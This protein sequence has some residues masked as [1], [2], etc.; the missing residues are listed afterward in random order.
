MS[1]L[2]FNQF[3]STVRQYP[4]NIAIETDVNKFNYHELLDDVN[5]L[6]NV[7]EKIDP[8]TEQFVGLNID[9]SYEYI[10]ALL[11]VNKLKKIFAPMGAAYPVKRIER[12]LDKTNMRILITQQGYEEV[13]KQL[14]LENY[15]SFD[16]ECPSGIGFTIHQFSNSQRGKTK[17]SLE[18]VA[19]LLSTSGSTGEPKLILGI[20]KGLDHFI[21]WQKEKFFIGVGCRCSLLSPVT[22]DVSLR[23]ILVPLYSG[24]AIVIPDSSTRQD[25]Y[26]LLQ[27]L[28]KKQI[29]LTHMVPTIFRGLLTELESQQGTY[30]LSA[31]SHVVLPG[32]PLYA[33]DVVQWEKLVGRNTNLVI[34]YGPS[35]TS[36]AKLFYFV[37]FERHYPDGVI[38]IGELLPD[39]EISILDEA[40][41]EIAEGQVGELC[42]HTH[43][44][45]KGYL[46]LPQ[47][48]AEVF[49]DAGT[50]KA[51]Y[52]TGDLVFRGEDGLIYF[53]GRKDH[54]V[55]LRGQRIELLEV[56]SVLKQVANV[57]HAVAV[58]KTDKQ[59][60]EK[61]VVYLGGIDKQALPVDKIRQLMQGHLPDYMLP[62][63]IMYLDKLP[64]NAN[65]KVDRHQLPDLLTQ[66]P[67]LTQEYV[68]AAT[69]FEIKLVNIWQTV[70]GLEPLGIRDNFFDLGGTSNQILAMLSELRRTFAKEV[71]VGNAFEYGSIEKLAAF[72][73]SDSPSSEKLKARTRRIKNNTQTEK[74][75]AIVGMALSVPD[76][77]TVEQFWKNLLTGKESITFFDNNL[78]ESVSTNVSSQSNYVAARGIL[79]NAWCFDAPFFNFSEREAQVLDPQQRILL[80]LSYQA[81]QDA[82]IVNDNYGGLIGVFAGVGDNSYYSK[83]LLNNEEAQLLG[84]QALRLANEKDYVATRIAHVLNLK[85]MAISVHTACSTSLV[86]VC[87]AV[88]ALR[89]GSIDSALCGGAYIPYPQESGHLHAEG[90]FASKDGHC[91]PFDAEASGTLFSSGAGMV[92]LKRLS[93]AIEEGDHV[94][95]TIKGVGV[96]N[97]GGGKMSFMSPSVDGQAQAIQMAVD[98]AAVSHDSIEY[99]EAHGTATPLGDPIEVEALARIYK[100]VKNKTRLLG[101][102]KSNLGHLDAAAGVVGLIKV[103]LSLKYNTLPPSINY[104]TPNPAIPFDA[105]SFKVND[106][107]KMLDSEEPLQRV[108]VSSFGVGGTNAHVIV[109]APPISEFKHVEKNI[110]GSELLLLSAESAHSLGA[111]E[112]ALGNFVQGNKAIKISQVAANLA[113]NR[114]HYSHRSFAVCHNTETAQDI[115]QNRPLKAY[116]DNV[117]A[118]NKQKKVAFLFPGQGSQHVGM[119]ACFYQTDAVYTKYLDQ[120]A[121]LLA[122]YVDWDIRDIL[123]P[124]S[125]EAKQTAN[126]LINQTAYSQPALFVVCYAM[127]K[128]WQHLGVQ[129]AAM[130]GH[131]IGEYVAAC[132]AEVLN[133]DDALK[134]ILARGRLMQSM[135]E[136]DMLSVSLS[137]AEL[138]PYLHRQLSIAAINSSKLTVVAGDSNSI[139]ALQAELNQKSIDNKL[140]VT[141]HAF[142]S[143]MMEPVLNEFAAEFQQVKL[144]QA[145]TTIISS[146]TADVLT[147]AQATDINY[148]TSHVRNPVRFYQAVETLWANDDYI[149]LEVG[150]RAT[151][152]AL[153]NLVINDPAKQLAIASQGKSVELADMQH[154]F[155]FAAGQLWT[156]GINLDW[157]AWYQH[158]LVAKLSLPNYIFEPL[159]YRLDGITTQRSQEAVLQAQTIDDVGQQIARLI[160]QFTGTK[161]DIGFDQTFIALGLDSL[162]L[163]QFSL[164]LQKIFSVQI[165]VSRLLG[166][167]VTPTLLIETIWQDLPDTEELSEPEIHKHVFDDI[168]IVDVDDMSEQD[169]S[170]GMDEKGNPQWY[171]R[172]SDE[173]GYYYQYK[174]DDKQSSLKR[175]NYNPFRKGNIESVV[176]M[177][178]S[179]SEIWLSAQ[180]DDDAS[181]AFNLSLCMSFT[182]KL[183]VDLLEKAIHIIV[184][185]HE[186]LRSTF[187]AD[188]MAMVIYSDVNIEFNQ[189]LLAGKT[190]DERLEEL[191]YEEDNICN[192]LFDLANGPLFRVCLFKLNDEKSFLTFVAH[193]MVVDG[194]SLDLLI[195][196][197]E[198]VYNNLI[199]QRKLDMPDAYSIAKYNSAIVSK[200]LEQIYINAEKYWVNQYKDSIPILDLPLYKKRPVFRTYRA[201][202]CEHQLSQQTIDVMNQALIECNTTF[203]AFAYSVYALLLHKLSKQDDIAIGVPYA[204]QIATGN[205]HLFGHCVNMLPIR[206]SVDKKATVELFMQQ[207]QKQ[208][209]T[210]QDNGLLTFSDLIGKVNIPRDTSRIPIISTTFNID[211]GNRQPDFID[212]DVAYEYHPRQ[213]ETFELA[214]TIIRNADVSKVQCQ[215]NVDLFTNEQVRNWLEIYEHLIQVACKGLTQELGQLNALPDAD[216]ALFDK[217]NNTKFNYDGSKCIGDFVS[218]TA[219]KFPNKTAVKFENISYT[220]NELNENS[221]AIA[222]ALIEYGV[223]PN[224]FVGLY[225]ERSAETLIVLLGILKSGAG[226]LPLDPE[227]PAERISFILDDAKANILISQ[228]KLNDNIAGFDGNILYQDDLFADLANYNKERPRTNL[229]SENLAYTIYTSG[230]TGKPKGVQVTHK[231]VVNFLLSMLER[232]GLQ[233]DDK[234][235]AVTT[236]SFD[237]HVLEMFLPLFCGATVEVASRDLSIDGQALIDRIEQSKITVMQATPSTW[238]MML[239][240]GWSK[241]RKIKALIGGEALPKDILPEL[242]DNTTELWN[243]YGPTETTVWSTCKLIQDP[244][245]T[246]TVGKPIAN[247]QIYILNENLMHVPIGTAG[248]LY[249]GGDGVTDGYLYRPELNKERFIPDLFSGKADVKVYRTGDEVRFRPDGEIEYL[250]RIDNQV[251]VRGYR[252]ELGEIESVLIKDSEIKQCVVIAREDQPGD[253]RLVAYYILHNDQADIDN[254]YLKNAAGKDLP[255]YMVPQHYVMLDVLPL[256]PNGK[257][258]RKQLPKP[259]FN[260][261][262]N[263]G[264]YIKPEGEVEQKIANI[265][266]ELIGVK[267]VGLFDNFFNIGG[268]S[269]LAMKFI[270]K[271]QQEFSVKLKFQSIMLDTLQNIAKLCGSTHIQTTSKINN[272]SFE[273]NIETFYFGQDSQLYGIHYFA[274]EQKPNSKTILICAP[275]SQDSVRSQM[276]LR[277]L[278][279]KLVKQG[280][281]VLRFD[282]YGTGDSFGMD[283]QASLERWKT[284]VVSAVSFLKQKNSQ[285]IISAIGVRLGATILMDVQGLD[286]GKIVLWDPVID[287][288]EHVANLKA[289]QKNMLKDL[290]NYRWGRSEEPIE[291]CLELSAFNYSI[292]NIAEIRQLKIN[293]NIADN[294]VSIVL[295]KDLYENAKYIG[296]LPAGNIKKLNSAGEWYNFVKQDDMLTSPDIVKTISEIF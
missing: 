274:N 135:P 152:T 286:F 195:S 225:A 41:S 76:A 130:I 193:H 231:N 70:L 169:M 168:E 127:A 159:E 115:L 203:F 245:E 69:E 2:Q 83:V 107:L 124:D 244:N 85:G 81:L 87:Q 182:G 255:P 143:H 61:L 38:P 94:Y 250:N 202:R 185:R 123:Y 9:A 147:E 50:E 243:M 258:D 37:E 204:G 113:L 108:A 90:G 126:T 253:V 55:K 66:R 273:L 72:I 248:E 139:A 79:D 266:S 251:K 279:E 131:S 154:S 282:Y 56:E 224:E 164:S 44:L 177:T 259:V 102:V 194:W 47:K 33:R 10:A 57:T 263:E 86:A 129:P 178:Q 230:S 116:A 188:K 104:H 51:R 285:S 175:V 22:F 292:N 151:A 260:D 5:Y 53:K 36:V 264:N 153:A 134:I 25:P 296:S 184:V 68:P 217:W 17:Q 60:E 97:D 237:I 120:C 288:L 280:Y 84:D 223:K 122:N 242:I 146:A 43:L 137:E 109:D 254:L 162:S 205:K 160:Q 133:L 281:N 4:N 136:G 78:H 80:Q 132:L 211:E 40:G 247:T 207:V 227:Y 82:C 114:V 26:K 239:M 183:Q 291:G 111:A 142:H 64:V 261:E 226:Y 110:Y 24:G 27:W 235:L 187:S 119:G 117:V 233:H 276:L 138:Q 208:L 67:Y 174:E 267:Q 74:D 45:S 19:Y 121:D 200:R 240:A 149:C 222:H 189:V 234:I 294:K 167:C 176:P 88:E 15:E 192:Q 238:R 201:N 3:Q 166:D 295:S 141:S 229:N 270:S 99:I 172:Q 42:I 29:T 106:Q 20:E 125:E 140:L 150:P 96:N 65:G 170:L 271:V 39:T 156:A 236:V 91:R 290:Y 246:I 214:T 75:I 256:T 12:I 163:T 89:A 6:S 54:Q 46:G 34:S 209:F 105:Y 155:V 59:A 73:A 23:D 71:T 215:Y 171:K 278:A 161:D 118:S 62:S 8:V 100:P 268:H 277:M 241:G 1:F 186:A 21:N 63:A 289:L 98:D 103:A 112:Q 165:P 275:I 283:T 49:L 14:S 293:N 232:P 92:V 252:I 197:L 284:D 30:D 13:I 52:L 181:K 249:I 199:Q 206:L 158:Q 221:N 144:Q 269:L 32:E 213:Y 262:I 128:L 148:W 179:Q 95:A 265:W 93:D 35:E 216:L 190:D 257:I 7:L 220:Y 145:H 58:I 228:K 272:N 212:L 18:G 191:A 210:A 196:E 77:N 287:G 101:S 198:Q 31:L 173:K 11:A 219:K 157:Q 218:E 180:Q 28:S 16:V 48:Q